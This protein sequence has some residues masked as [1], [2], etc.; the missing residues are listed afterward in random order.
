LERAGAAN[1]GSE[2]QLENGKETR[3]EE[4]ER[5]REKGKADVGLL[6][7]PLSPSSVSLLVLLLCQTANCQAE[8]GGRGGG[9]G[10]KPPVVM[11]GRVVRWKFL[12]WGKGLKVHIILWSQH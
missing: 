9:G 1:K 4:E 10:K 5:A 12:M 6:C 2:Q 3:G 8:L 7:L 11:W